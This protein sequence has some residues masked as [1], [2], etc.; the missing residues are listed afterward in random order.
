MFRPDAWRMG[1]L[2]TAQWFALVGM[3]TGAVALL[4]NHR[5]PRRPGEERGG[6]AA[7]PEGSS[8]VEG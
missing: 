3:A 2:A 7:Y 8:S 1:S 4:I 5:R 6:A